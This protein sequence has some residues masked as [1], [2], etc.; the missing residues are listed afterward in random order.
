MK[1]L[2]ASSAAAA[3]AVMA[4]AALPG[5]ASTQEVA[6]ERVNTLILYG[7]DECPQSVPGEITVCAR[8]DEGE[9]YRV[10]EVLR[11]DAQGP[12]NES[13]AERVRAFE[14]VGDFGPLS[15]SPVGAGGELGCT[16]ELIEAAY[17]EKMQR[18]GVRFSQLIEEERQKRLA[19]ID[20][21]AATV[22]ARV[23]ELE[24]RYAAEQ[25][26][27]DPAQEPSM[28]LE[29]EEDLPRPVGAQVPVIIEP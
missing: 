17:A 8:L 15:C 7:D 18:P 3:A 2:I 27:V 23:E 13:W 11:E 28:E 9:R 25:A 29:E 1:R 22:Q 21:E 5:S 6:G 14:A 24:R 26:G 19:E 10:P 12:A 20:A 4:L 16:A